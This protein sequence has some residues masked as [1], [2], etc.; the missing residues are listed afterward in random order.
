MTTTWMRCALPAF[1]IVLL[2]GCRSLSYDPDK[3]VYLSNERAFARDGV[4]A[5]FKEVLPAEKP[6]VLFVHGRGNEPG[7]S[8]VGTGLLSQMYGLEGRAVH[9]LE[10]T[11]R[12]P[13]VLFS[14]DSK[15]NPGLLN[16]DLA[17]RC[18]PLEN[19]VEA[20]ERLRSVVESLSSLKTERPR[21]VLLAHSMGTWVVKNYV[22]K[23]GPF[24]KGLFA[25]VVLSSADVDNAGHDV[26]VQTLA[27]TSRVYITVNE[28][29]EILL[30]ATKSCRKE[31]V[32]PLGRVPGQARASNA[33]YVQFPSMEAHEIFFRKEWGKFDR[34]RDFYGA[35]LS[36]GEYRN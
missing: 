14:W 12:L 19:S 30:Q 2:A 7:K 9:N 21:V 35:V 1:A 36:G 32:L 34:V 25:N 17:D 28:G 6:V 3:F 10:E 22:E 4:P 13:V 31:G 20:A 26:W 15:R 11:Y 23:Y 27:A 29:D 18:R 24:P 5:A 16:L 33:T 8:L